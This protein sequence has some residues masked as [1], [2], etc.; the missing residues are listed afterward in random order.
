MRRSIILR[1]TAL[2]VLFTFICT[3][4]TTP[5]AFAKKSMNSDTRNW[6]NIG[7]YLLGGVMLYKGLPN[8]FSWASTLFQP[9]VQ[10]YVYKGLRQAGVNETISFIGAAG[11]TTLG[12]SLA[13]KTLLVTK[14]NQGNWVT[15]DPVRP[16]KVLTNKENWTGFKEAVKNGW[17]APSKI[18]GLRGALGGNLY[19]AALNTVLKKTAMAMTAAGVQ[20]LGR[21]YI[22]INTD[23]FNKADNE[24]Y[25]HAGGLKGWMYDI[26]HNNGH[27][28]A[29][30]VNLIVKDWTN[31]AAASIAAGVGGVIAYAGN[32]PLV[33]RAVAGADVTAREAMWKD[34]KQP[35]QYAYVDADIPTLVGGPGLKTTYDLDGKVPV[36]ILGFKEINKSG[37]LGALSNA[38]YA[39]WQGVGSLG[40]GFHLSHALIPAVAEFTYYLANKNPNWFPHL[41]ANEGGWGGLGG[42]K[43][44]RDR[45]RMNNKSGL[46]DG[47]NLDDMSPLVTELIYGTAGA[48][49]DAIDQAMIGQYRTGESGSN[50]FFKG[51]AL[52]IGKTLVIGYVSLGL[53]KWNKDL[54]LDPV[55][56]NAYVSGVSSVL[57]GTT[58][59][60]VNKYA[61]AFNTKQK[62]NPGKWEFENNNNTTLWKYKQYE[63]VGETS[64]LKNIAQAFN[65]RS[66]NT[67]ERL[68]TFGQGY[69]NAALG[70]H[71]ARYYTAANA[72]VSDMNLMG[73]ANAIQRYISSTYHYGAFDWNIQ[74]PAL[75]E[76]TEKLPNQK[77]EQQV[78]PP[79]PPPPAVEQAPPPAP[80]SENPPPDIEINGKWRTQQVSHI[81][82]SPAINGSYPYWNE[83][84]QSGMAAVQAIDNR[85]EYYRWE[86]D[87]ERPGYYRVV[88]CDANGLP[89]AAEQNNGNQWIQHSGLRGVVANRDGTYSVPANNN[90]RDVF[91]RNLG[92]GTKIWVYFQPVWPTSPPAQQ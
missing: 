49:G 27:D 11:L 80:K 91:E 33:I 76:K 22:A 32:Q 12:F 1:I 26:G 60:L 92:Q 2:L 57:E 13:E 55:A 4:F 58:Q 54:K 14:D 45:M 59:A 42:N 83:R 64:I 8:N 69:A 88:P 38:S 37:L 77:I 82:E 78:Q 34:L 21:M 84:W 44:K 10:G 87:P 23:G 39:F 74:K 75:V 50:L 67:V 28:Y 73:P 16:W 65:Q 62:N 6:L 17:T 43:N 18:D 15:Y 61:R 70:L 52:G 36:E 40:L 63:N 9:I 29:D 48:L 72:F 24:K 81:G 85:D 89:R 35:V 3:S 53:Q 90:N 25:K 71:D 56:F 68:L 30:Y 20:E 79:P 7:G 5:T 66:I 86:P 51:L 47:D 19:N 41:N 31:W 46:Y